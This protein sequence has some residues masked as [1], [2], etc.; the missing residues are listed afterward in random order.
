MRPPQEAIFWAMT[1]LLYPTADQISKTFLGCFVSKNA[2]KNS[3]VSLE[4][5]G[6]RLTSQLTLNWSK[7]LVITERE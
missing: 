6:I 4:I 2:S 3:C 5:N 1:M 7:K